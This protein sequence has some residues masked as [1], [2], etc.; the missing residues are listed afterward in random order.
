MSRKSD[1]WVAPIGEGALIFAVGALGWALK[2]PLVFTSLG[3]TAY[4]LVEQPNTKSARA[5]NVIAGHV[6]ALTAG[7]FGLWVTHAYAAPT[8]ASAGFVS[9]P[10]LWATVIAVSLT[11]M[12]TLALHASQP[13]SLST[14]LLV[15]LGSMQT[16]RDAV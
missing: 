1:L 4:E 2:Q 10:R 13:A 14:T 6:V 3:P 8:V 5:Y 7:H 12:L 16:V 11:T 9:A 15:S